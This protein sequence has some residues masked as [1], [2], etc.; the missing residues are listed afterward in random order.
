MAKKH[1]IIGFTQADFKL[2]Q[3]GNEFIEAQGIVL[4]QQLV[5]HTCEV[6]SGS[7]MQVLLNKLE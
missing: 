1:L 5:N 7:R 6:E 3:S 2:A 4:F